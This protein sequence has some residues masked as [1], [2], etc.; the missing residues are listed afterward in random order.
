M[1]HRAEPI[2]K[3]AAPDFPAVSPQADWLL[4]PELA[5]LNQGAFSAIPRSI[6][7]AQTVWRDRIDLN[8]ARFYMEELFSELAD[9]A[10][11]LARFV[12]V[13]PERLAFVENATAGM[14]TV[15][16]DF[17][18][19]PGDRV[20]MTSH[21]YG[22]V[23]NTLQHLSERYGVVVDEVM[24]PPNPEDEDAV[25]APITAA[26]ATAPRLLVVDHITSAS[27]LIFPIAAIVAV[28]RTAG[29][30]VLVDGS[31]A[32]GM[33]ALDVD[34]INAHWY[35]GNCH[36]WLCAPK[37]AAFLARSADAP[38]PHP[39]V[40]SHAYGQGFPAEF[41]KIGTRDPSSMLTVPSALALHEELGGAGLRARNRALADAAAG[42]IADA[43]GGEI[44]GP[45]SMRGAMASIR[46]PGLPASFDLATALRVRLRQQHGIES[47]AVAFG[48]AMWMRVS[49]HAYNHWGQYEALAAA[50][51]GVIAELGVP[52]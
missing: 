37:G 23:R 46:L 7:A 17:D 16:A 15:L 44:L 31:H 6:R 22:A 50:L 19:R 27:A 29:V 49:A 35:V 28:A 25:L 18:F 9:A 38:A 21:V 14:A 4:D 40:I 1:Q 13:A 41:R 42:L 30:P 26:L 11:P 5:Y 32:P 24:L 3:Q 52:A 8:P 33:I 39:L 36:K 20:V 48:G 34:A 2:A 45:A 12:G 47:L 43:V 51:P 10:L